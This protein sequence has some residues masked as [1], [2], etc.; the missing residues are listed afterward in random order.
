MSEPHADSA[1]PRPREKRV[2]VLLDRALSASAGI[3]ALSAL[4]VS[5]YQAWIAREQQK[6]SA[7]PY[8]TQTNT[9]AGGYGRLVQNVGLG[10][11]LVRSMRVDVDGKP[12][13]Q[14]SALLMSALR[15]DTATLRARLPG[16]GYTTSSV[17]PGMVLLPGTTSELI[18]V[19]DSAFAGTLRGVM[20]DPRVHVRI[21]YCSLYGDCWV[22]DSR[23]LEPAAVRACPTLDE[24]LEFQS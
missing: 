17:R 5:I 20:N 16:A 7:W 12:V 24:S 22:S 18:H 3:V 11:A 19:S 15:V 8:V 23:A 1:T 10:P 4:G 14:W 2:R 6:M 9:G 21:C 13:R